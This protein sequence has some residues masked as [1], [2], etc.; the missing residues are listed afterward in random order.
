MHAGGRAVH[1]VTDMA[2]TAAPTMLV[3]CTARVDLP[4]TLTS[5]PWGASLGSPFSLLAQELLELVH[6]LLRIEGV[7]TLWARR[8]VPRRII[9]LL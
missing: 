8:L 4:W 6:Q 3:S 2:T 1:V 5:Q 7:V 9:V